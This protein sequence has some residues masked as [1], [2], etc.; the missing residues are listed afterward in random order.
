M[1]LCWEENLESLWIRIN[2]LLFLYV[3]EKKCSVEMTASSFSV[4]G[5]FWGEE[6][7]QSLLAILGIAEV[8]AVRILLYCQ[9]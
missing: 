9:W 3:L 8:S 5:G 4:E 7:F 2:I 1:L 6:E